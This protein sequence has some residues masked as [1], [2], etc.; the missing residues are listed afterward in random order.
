MV[1]LLKNDDKRKFDD[2]KDEDLYVN[3]RLIFEWKPCAEGLF[4]YCN[5]TLRET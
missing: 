3:N 4:F 2:T 1:A 5:Y